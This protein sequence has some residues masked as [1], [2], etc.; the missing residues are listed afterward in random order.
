M[1]SM[2][3]ESWIPLILTISTFI[4]FSLYFLLPRHGDREGR[5]QILVLG[6][7]GHSPR[8]QYH[9]LSAAKHGASVDMIGYLGTLKNQSCFCSQQC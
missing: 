6:D 4:S 7:I 9:A 8:M 1:S 5:V 2:S 3:S